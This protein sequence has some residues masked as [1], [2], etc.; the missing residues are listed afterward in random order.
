MLCRRS[1]DFEHSLYQ[2][3][4]FKDL[5]PYVLLPAAERASERGRK[6][7][8]QGVFLLQQHTV[9]YARKQEAWIRNRLLVHGRDV[10]TPF[11]STVLNKQPILH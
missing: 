4:G 7:L 10:S 1:R 11:T 9:R 8:E 6:V 5:L 2:S 3:I